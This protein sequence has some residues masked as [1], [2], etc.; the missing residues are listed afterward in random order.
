[1]IV[2]VHLTVQ[3]TIKMKLSKIFHLLFVSVFAIPFVS[4][5][6][7]IEPATINIKALI[8]SI[9]DSLDKHYIFPEKAA[10][11]SVYLQ[12]QL[13][14]NAYNQMLDNP[15]KLATQI[16]ADIHRSHHDLHM[17]VHYDPDF[18][19]QKM[20]NQTQEEM[21]NAKRFW[22]ENNYMFKKV[23]VL[24][25]NIGYFPI[26]GF[27]EEIKGAKPTITA[28]LKFVSNTKALIIDLRKNMGGS[29]EMVSLIESYFFKEKSPMNHIINRSENDTT[30]YYADPAKSD[31]LFL[32]MPVYILTSKHTFSAAEDF[33]YGMQ[34]AKRAIIV[35]DTTGGGAHPQLPFSVGNGFVVSIPFA[36]SFNPVTKTDWEGTGV[37]PDVKASADEALIKAQELI[38]RQQLLSTTS[39]KEKNINLYYIN[40]LMIIKRIIRT[41]LNKLSLL[42]GTY[43]GI[44]IYLDKNK[45]YCKNNYKGGFVSEL[46]NLSNNLFVLDENAQI[47][48]VKDDKGYFSQIKILVNDGNIFEEKRVKL[49]VK[50]D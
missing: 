48:F 19:P 8:R 39:Q 20:N 41:S 43:G 22:T 30:F 18:V 9:T 7:R 16:E 34:M 26:E 21:A 37:I 35:G 49:L 45:L 10:G 47:E 32:S 38:F 11:I 5:A 27:V 46:Y 23:E 28:A 3:I 33:S 24:P 2:L 42:T 36:R 50:Q 40:S 17:R 25:G 31:S 29:P 14:N 12:S 15:R 13:K 44:V 4:S 1:M 6:Q